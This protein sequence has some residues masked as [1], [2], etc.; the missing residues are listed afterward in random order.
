MERAGGVGGRDEC[1]C[2]ELL[3]FFFVVVMSLRFSQDFLNLNFDLTS[4]LCHS[5]SKVL[6]LFSL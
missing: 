5:T 4:A 1:A 6:R 3:L 2:V